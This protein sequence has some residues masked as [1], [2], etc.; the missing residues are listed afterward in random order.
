VPVMDLF[1][2]LVFPPVLLCPALSMVLS[3]SSILATVLC[4]PSSSGAEKFFF[5]FNLGLP[6]LIHS[7][8]DSPLVFYGSCG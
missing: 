6:H 5:P 3:R 1:F 2:S 7:G 8:S 4:S